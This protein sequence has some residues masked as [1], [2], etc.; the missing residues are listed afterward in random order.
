MVGRVPLDPLPPSNKEPRKNNSSATDV[1][2]TLSRTLS[3]RRP[4][5]SGRRRHECLRHEVHAAKCEVIS[6]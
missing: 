4:D 6:A 5:E 1:A 3:L 2:Q